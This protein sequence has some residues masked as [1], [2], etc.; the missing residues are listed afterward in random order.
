M[1]D[2][3]LIRH[4]KDTL[5]NHLGVADKGVANLIWMAHESCKSGEWEDDGE[6]KWT[7]VNMKGVPE[8]KVDG[9]IDDFKSTTLV[10][11]EDAL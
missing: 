4:I 1:D 2:K 7:L 9:L 5:V 8:D 10:N 11:D 3:Q 6:L